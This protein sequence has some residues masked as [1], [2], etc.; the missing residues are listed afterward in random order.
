MNREN[1]S[2]QEA[3]TDDYQDLFATERSGI[4]KWQIRLEEELS[5]REP[6]DGWN[7]DQWRRKL[8][9][10]NL[11]SDNYDT[12]V[13]LDWPHYCGG[14]TKGCGGKDGWCYTLGGQLGGGAKRSRRAAMTDSLARHHPELFG[15]IVAAEIEKLVSTREIRYPNL[16]FSGSGEL[17]PAHLPAILQVK[18]QGINLWGFSRNI[19]M[20]IALQKHEISVLFSCDATTPDSRIAEAREHGL[21]LAYTSTGVSDKPPEGTFVTFPLHRSGK[22]K[23]IVLANSVCPKVAQE[24]LDGKRTRA[25]CQTKCARCH[26]SP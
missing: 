15:E 7:T 18:A 9:A 2:T 22:V 25:A 19:R 3:I 20:A 26:H 8:K 13:S 24:Y 5:L 6:F 4:K 1:L 11:L 14:A 16:R 21:G 12:V 17:H 23:E 10:A